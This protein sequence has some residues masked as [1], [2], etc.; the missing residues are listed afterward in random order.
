[1]AEVRRSVGHGGR[2]DSRRLDGPCRLVDDD[3]D[4]TERIRPA[5]VVGTDDLLIDVIPIDFLSSLH[6]PVKSVVGG[7]ERRYVE[8]RYVS[9][10]K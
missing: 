7:Y 1:M 6:I 3:D 9:C 2:R 10:C 4:A 5:A 8:V